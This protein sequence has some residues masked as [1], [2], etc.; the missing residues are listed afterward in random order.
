MGLMNQAMHEEDPG[1]GYGSDDD[2]VELKKIHKIRMNQDEKDSAKAREIVDEILRLSKDAPIH[3]I[4]ALG[5][6]FPSPILEIGGDLKRGDWW[7]RY[8]QLE[9]RCFP[10]KEIR[11][12]KYHLELRN[13]MGCKN[14]EESLFKVIKDHLYC[15]KFS[16]RFI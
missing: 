12:K 6:T 13:S 16:Y 4:R 7:A 2:A 11:G 15:K 14:E 9:E 5:E 10:V 8:A 1:Y 3:E